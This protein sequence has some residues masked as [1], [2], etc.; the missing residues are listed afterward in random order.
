MP[1][2][3]VYVS[4]A[5]LKNEV[6]KIFIIQRP[7]HK[8][9]GGYYEFPGGKIEPQETP[10]QAI[11]REL[12][13]ELGIEVVEGD[14]RP[15]NFFSYP[16]PDFHLVMFTYVIDTWQG[17]IHPKED[18]GH[19]TWIDVEDFDKYPTPPADDAIIDQLKAMLRA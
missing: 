17:E 6:G 2:P 1:H 8:K 4:A 9:L 13:E 19:F 14:L 7:S 12:H 15:L 16:Y 10:E 18:Q 5:I 11:V 3:I